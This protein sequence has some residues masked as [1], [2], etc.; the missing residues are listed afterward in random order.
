M[1]RRTH[2]LLL[3]IVVTFAAGLLSGSCRGPSDVT[4]E[5]TPIRVTLFTVGTPISTLVV[6]VTAAD[7][8]NRLVFNI[9]VVGVVATGTIDVPAGVARTFTV[10]AFDDQNNVTHEGS[11]TT[12][13]SPGPNPP[14][15]IK[16]KP[17]AGQVEVTVTFGTFSVLVAPAAAIIDAAI[18]N[19]LQGSHRDRGGWPT[20]SEPAGPVGHNASYL[21]S[22]F[23]VGP[24]YWPRGRIRHH[25]RI[26]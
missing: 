1:A 8:T 10:T 16:L 3:S 24:G 2:F 26:V 4:E 9:E 5:L 17:I 12:D 18:S 20:C 21:G 6:E 23:S 11:E 13:V 25:C 15:R 14:L 19:Q 22:S 7:I